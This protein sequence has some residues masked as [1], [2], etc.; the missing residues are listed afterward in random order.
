MKLN[1]G[2]ERHHY[3]MFNVGCWM[4]DVHLSKQLSAYGANQIDY[5]IKSRAVAQLTYDLNPI[6]LAIAPGKFLTAASAFADKIGNVTG[7]EAHGLFAGVNLHRCV[8]RN[9]CQQ[10]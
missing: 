6:H 1:C 10:F 5:R 9:N 7:C 4:F 3:S 2:A 8:L